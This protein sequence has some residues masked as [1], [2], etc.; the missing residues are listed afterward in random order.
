MAHGETPTKTLGSEKFFPRLQQCIDGYKK[1]DPVSQKKLPVE[2]NVPK[3]LVECALD[4]SAN[5]LHKAVGGLSLIAFYYLL[6][7]GEYTTK[8]KRDN[9][10]HTI[11]FKMEDVQVFAKDRRG[12]LWCHP[13]DASDDD[14]GAAAGMAL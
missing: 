1:Q 5:E 4:S 9:S 8:G 11:Q 14:I 13:R 12:R 6:W 10:E 7:V 3:Y 2:A